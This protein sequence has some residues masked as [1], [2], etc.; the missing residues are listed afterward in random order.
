MVVIRRRARSF[1]DDNGVPLRRAQPSFKTDIL[2]VFHY[3]LGARVQ[4]LAML[5]LGRNAGESDILTEFIDEAGLVPLE[6]VD[7]GLHRVSLLG[8]QQTFEK[9]AHRRLVCGRRIGLSVRGG[10]GI[11][12]RAGAK[13]AT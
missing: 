11:W 5:R 9:I 1:G 6:V 2:A 4:I 12:I 8:I 3:P 13:E 7:N 10:V